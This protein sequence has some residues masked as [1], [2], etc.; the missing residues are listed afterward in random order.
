MRKFN[1]ERMKNKVT[2]PLNWGLDGKKVNED[3]QEPSQSDAIQGRYQQD[4]RVATLPFLILPFISCYF[5]LWFAFYPIEDNVK[6]NF[7][8]E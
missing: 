3:D 7:E 8:G 4:T 2:T 5:I 1:L 6:F